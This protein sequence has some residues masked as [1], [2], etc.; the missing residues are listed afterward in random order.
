MRHVD[1]GNY[2]VKKLDNVRRHRAL[3]QLSSTLIGKSSLGDLC[4]DLMSNSFA[5]DCEEILDTLADVDTDGSNVYH[6]FYRFH[7]IEVIKKKVFE[8]D[9]LCGFMLE[10]SPTKVNIAYGV[11]RKE[12]TFVEG[13][14]DV[15]FDGKYCCGLYFCD[16]SI[17]DDPKALSVADFENDVT[18]HCL[19]LPYPQEGKSDSCYAMMTGQWTVLG[20]DGSLK[21]PEY[22]IQLF[23]ELV[24]SWLR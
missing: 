11:G 17:D 3:K 10:G 18:G 23:P 9:I 1:V 5:D 13:T 24:L 12:I 2:M 20:E 22:V 7:S 16:L 21:K 15:A 6:G 19:I 4:S 14:F 8:G